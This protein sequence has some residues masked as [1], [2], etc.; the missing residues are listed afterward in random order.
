MVSPHLLSRVGALQSGALAGV[1]LSF[2]D[3]LQ[4][5]LFII[6]GNFGFGID[7]HIDL[8]IKY[9]TS[10]GIFGMDFTIVLK[11]AGQ[12]VHLRRAKT[13]RIGK[14]QR[15]TQDDAKLWFIENLGGT[16]LN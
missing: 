16:I 7:E 2:D 15:V 5:Y 1:T 3:L 8:G 6:S 10:T 13:N 12:R 14:F 9:D 11:R 4:F